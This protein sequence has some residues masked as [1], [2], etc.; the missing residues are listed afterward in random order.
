MPAL[1]IHHIGLLV[2]DIDESRGAYL[3]TGYEAITGV[4]H[5]PVQTAYVQFLR[6]PG[7]RVYLELVAPDGP[8]SK[9]ANER[10]KGGGLNHICYV[11]D[12]IAAACAELRD[13]GYFQIA[14]PVPAVAF[15]G[16]CVAWMMGPD[17]LLTELVERGPEGSL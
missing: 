7:D 11:T 15:S 9:L 6:L 1:N 8:E 3:R 14:E 5:D 12:D 4:I 2:R 13:L 16:R 10:R 17:R